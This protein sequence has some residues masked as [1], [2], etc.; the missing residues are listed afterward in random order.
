MIRIPGVVTAS[1]SSFTE[2]DAKEEYRDFEGTVKELRKYI[3]GEKHQ[4]MT[5]TEAD[6]FWFDFDYVLEGKETWIVASKIW[7]FE[8]KYSGDIIFC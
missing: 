8:L 4:S 2:V 7:S 6:D 1:G 5:E 3:T